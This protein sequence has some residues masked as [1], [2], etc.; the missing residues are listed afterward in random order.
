M[1]VGGVAEANAHYRS[2]H[3]Y[4]LGESDDFDPEFAIDRCHFWSFLEATQA[5]GL[6]KLKNRPNWQRL[7]LER[8]SRKIQKGGL[9]IDDAAYPSI[10]W[11]SYKSLV[12]ASISIV[13][14]RRCT[15]PLFT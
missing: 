8:L 4:W 2:G 3:L 11:A 14:A 13:A 12:V 10:L 15:V 5:E 1:K 6:A 7:I 9:R